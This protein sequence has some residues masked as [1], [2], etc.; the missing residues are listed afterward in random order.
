MH[1]FHNRPLALACWCFAGAAIL[2]Y[3]IDA[4][5]SI[6]LGILLFLGAALLLILYLLRKRKQLFLGFLCLLFAFL[7]TFS[8]YQFFY[9][10]CA[11][12]RELI[13]EECTV[14]GTV[15]KVLN[16]KSYATS[17]HV[18]LRELNGE[19]CDGKVILKC[20]YASALQI[21]DR[22][23]ITATG[24]DFSSDDGYDEKAYALPDGILGVVIC[25][26]Q[27][28][29]EI[30]AEKNPS[31]QMMFCKWNEQMSFRLEE[32]VK[33]EEGHL[34]NALLFGNRD[35]LSDNTVLSFRRTGVSHL[36]ALSGLHVSIL[37]GLFEWLL[38]KLH[39][40]KLGRVITISILAVAYLFLTGCAPSTARAVL[41]LCMLNLGF[42]LRSNYDSFTALSLIL[43]AFLFVTP[44]AVTDIGMWMSFIAAASIVVFASAL[45]TAM[46]SFSE[47]KSIPR[48][49]RRL[50]SAFI[51][52]LFIGT[53]A[54]LALLLIQAFSFGEYSL[55]SVPETLL[56]SVPMT[57]TLIFSIIATVVT[58]L[59]F[60]CKICAGWMLKITNLLSG[61]EGILL[62]IGDTF[63]VI[64]MIIITLSL[65]FIAIFKLKRILL[66]CIL[67]L[68][69]SFCSVTLSM[70]VTKYQYDGVKVDY[71]IETGGEVML[72]SE[73]GQCIAV[74]FS[75]STGIGASAIAA[76]A[77]D[78]RCTELKDLIITHYH[79]RGAYFIHQL[80]GLIRVHNLRLP[81]PKNAWEAAVAE[82][83]TQEASLYGINVRYD[84]EELCISSLS[85]AASE[86]E[87]FSSGRHPALLLSVTANGQSLTYVNGSVPDSALSVHAGELIKRSEILIV[88]STGHSNDSDTTLPPL[89][90]S[91][92]TV[93][94]SDASAEHLLPYNAYRSEIRQEQSQYV[95]YLH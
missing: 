21:G 77:K 7:A 54:N 2:I 45:N 78:A 6:I 61:T 17:F 33:G 62:A 92:E 35:S 51:N 82:R 29:C 31:L 59:G 9:V 60:I 56:L 55:M 75:D 12:Y 71:R 25:H 23:S 15:L 5:L 19:P 38:R 67:P 50:L 66:W 68:A 69:L 27:E 87:L 34:A 30:L 20:E 89:G 48:V 52:A 24:A 16:A 28:N 63:S 36:L 76:A 70:L 73:N 1:L 80:S 18:Q 85:V 57:L 22:F 10:K 41:M 4:A 74:D 88:G 94:L 44:Y 90:D 83:M 42:L 8:S 64:L 81:T 40:T 3:N 39:V 58:P 14:E 65:L 46:K 95:F 13:G 11:P 79:N 93:I 37:I 47:K 86:H 91:V 72:F 43:A 84:T 49:I 53:V 32:A 26:S